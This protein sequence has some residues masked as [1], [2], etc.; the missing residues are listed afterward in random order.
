MVTNEGAR[1]HGLQQW[2]EAPTSRSR[3][4]SPEQGG[5]S[6][7]EIDHL[8]DRVV[9]SHRAV[10][11]T[12]S[13]DVR[14]ASGAQTAHISSGSQVTQVS[15]GSSS[16]LGEE[17]SRLGPVRSAEDSFK[18]QVGALRKAR[19]ERA[20][21]AAALRPVPSV[22]RLDPPLVTRGGVLYVPPSFEQ[23]RSLDVDLAHRL[24]MA[25]YRSV[26]GFLRAPEDELARLT[27][28]SVLSIRRAKRDLDLLRLP[29]VDERCGDLLRLIGCATVSRLAGMEPALL[30]RDV[31]RVMQQHRFLRLPAVLADEASIRRLV[32]AAKAR[33]E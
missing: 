28:L 12:L 2:S 8:V 13:E 18:K 1:S 25:G 27:G 22:S 15:H 5:R 14:G 19:R 31:E 3:E 9:D 24:V 17:I 29:Q 4:P 32:A 21:Q 16:P 20:Q 11:A 6:F 23:A 33:S 30:A 26:E 7:D 10:M